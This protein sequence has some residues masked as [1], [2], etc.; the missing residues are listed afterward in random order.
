MQD[1]LVNM[2][3]SNLHLD[4]NHRQHDVSMP[5]TPQVVPQ[6][7]PM[8]YITQHYHHSGHQA[9]AVTDDSA[10]ATLAN[11]GID[12]SVLSPSQLQLYKHALP[13][14]QQRLLELWRIAPPTPSDLA[15]DVDNWPQTSMNQE[16]EAA[17]YRWDIME[18]RRM[19]T[20]SN[21]TPTE[22]KMNAEPYIVTGYDGLAHPSMESSTDT[23][24]KAGGHGREWWNLSDNEPI[25]HQYGLL[26]YM[27]QS[28]PL[29]Y[30]PTHE[31]DMEMT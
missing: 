27:L 26:Q 7:T 6:M 23:E 8:T 17:Q 31:E 10:F 1:E 24:D 22:I 18:K 15:K 12:T 21:I 13:E 25:E 4:A 14:Q 3:T 30:R 28:Y 29:Q 20:T 2:M 19:N 16:E 11:A 5:P 9:A